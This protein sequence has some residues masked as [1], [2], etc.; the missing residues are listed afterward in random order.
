MSWPWPRIF[1]LQWSLR[2]LLV[3]I[4]LAAGSVAVVTRWPYQLS[5]QRQ[6]LLWHEGK[7]SPLASNDG[8]VRSSEELATYRGLIPQYRLRHG[9]SELFGNNKYSC[10]RLRIVER[11]YQGGALHGEYREFYTSGQVRTQG[12]YRF[13]HKHGQWLNYREQKHYAASNDY[14]LTQHWEVGKPHGLWQWE[15]GYGEVA[16]TAKYD[17]GKV[18]EVNGEAVIDWLKR[19][20]EVLPAD[21]LNVEWRR[22]LLES[23]DATNVDFRP[24]AHSTHWLSD[25]DIEQEAR[26]RS[27]DD[28]VYYPTVDR[29]PR[30]VRF[31]H[32]LHVMKMAFTVRHNMVFLTTPDRIGPEHDPTGVSQLKLSAG[33]LL[34]H[35]LAA[36]IEF[37]AWGNG[38]RNG[39]QAL[40]YLQRDCR[41][42]LDDSALHGTLE[43][44]DEDRVWDRLADGKT[45]HRVRDLLGITLYR[46]RCRCDLVE[47]QLVITRQP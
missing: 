25:Q 42:P 31:A 36:E 46:M 27:L 43:P 7:Q 20:A 38:Q 11:H 37:N 15:N 29:V 16:L 9:K 26:F 5:E 23:G 2:T 40:E 4:T 6:E 12:E 22:K 33:S 17:R 35:S 30:E 32:A 13:G 45:S 10:N 19:L 47:G 18:L 28:A 24:M 41:V 44:R 8:T 3:L 34:E 14:L 21:S 1:R 39:R